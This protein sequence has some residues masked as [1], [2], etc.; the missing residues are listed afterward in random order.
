MGKLGLKFTE[1]QPSNQS[2]QEREPIEKADGVTAA[3]KYLGRLCERS[4]LSLWSYPGLFRDQGKPQNGGHGKEICDLL[5]VF[6]QHIIIFSDKHCRFQNSGN[7]ELDWQRWF[8][9]AVQKSAEQAWGA[10]RWIQQNPARIFLDRECKQPLPINLPPAETAVFHLVVVAHGVSKHIKQLFRDSSGSLMINTDIKG[11]DKHIFPFYVGDL[12]PQKTF[13]HIFD[14]DSLQTLM[15]T[16]DTVSDFVA[17]LSKREELF[18][19]QRTIRATGEEQL[20]A[21]YL[22][23]LN[24]NNEHDFV[25]PIAPGQVVDK[26]FIPEGHWEDFQKAPERIAQLNVDKTSYAW[27][28]LIEKFNYHALQQKQYF[29]SPGGIKDTEQAL[30]FMAREP[31]WKRR[32]LAQSLMEMLKITPDNKRR[33]RVLPP[34]EK[35][36]PHYVFLL[37]PHLPSFTY[38]QYRTARRNFLESCCIVVRLEYPKATDIIGI[39]TESGM[40]RQDGRSEDL[41]YLDV[42]EWDENKD[43]HA[44]QLK[45]KFGILKKPQQIGFHLE[46]YPG[47]AITSTNM[48][49]PRNKPCPCG[50]GKKYKHCCLNK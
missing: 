29:V 33:L 31:R 20:L 11:F 27:D 3:E 26:I 22:K 48:K 14:D 2:G 7:V 25:F 30:R 45:D 28:G 6:G 17:Y 13:V 42:R 16:R 1:S 47:A 5:V 18:R 19:E 9:K 41:I 21:I 43:N 37:F 15:T 35:G 50:S 12:E 23:N 8:R 39:A 49:N 24:E 10:K 38:E 36:D 32:G 34:I 44:K 4:F 46:E 40:S